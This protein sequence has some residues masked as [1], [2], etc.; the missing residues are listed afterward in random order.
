MMPTPLAQWPAGLR[1]IAFCTTLAGAIG[2]LQD[3][4]IMLRSHSVDILTTCYASASTALYVLAVWFAFKAFRR[5]FFWVLLSASLLHV[6]ITA[7]YLWL[8]V[9]LAV[10][11]HEPSLV[12]EVSNIWNFAIFSVAAFVGYYLLGIERPRLFGSTPTRPSHPANTENS[13]AT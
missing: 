5:A 1:R 9:D 2:V 4:S 13:R 7:Y 8:I 3:A 12:F 11:L 10:Y 6:T